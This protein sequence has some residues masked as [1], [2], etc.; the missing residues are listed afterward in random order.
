MTF[1]EHL[2]TFTDARNSWAVVTDEKKGIIGHMYRF[3]PHNAT[4]I[5]DAYDKADL[6]YAGEIKNPIPKDSRVIID[7]WWQ[8]F[9][10]CYFRIKWEGNEYDVATDCILIDLPNANSNENSKAT[11]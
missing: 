11:G 5:K 8:N 10:G 3:A 4:V 1:M 2:L 9:Y 6:H 7:C